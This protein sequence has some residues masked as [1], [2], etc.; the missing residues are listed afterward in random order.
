MT[1]ISLNEGLDGRRDILRLITLLPEKEKISSLSFAP[2]IKISL[3]RRGKNLEGRD[4][5]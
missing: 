2:P 1:S 3:M 4:E 5:L